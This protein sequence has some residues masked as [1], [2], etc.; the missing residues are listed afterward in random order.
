MYSAGRTWNFVPYHKR[1]YSSSR[2]GRAFDNTR[3]SLIL[4]RWITSRTW[5]LERVLKLSQVPIA[6]EYTC[7]RI[8]DITCNSITTD[9]SPIPHAPSVRLVLTRRI[10]RA[11]WMR[12]GSQAWLLFQDLVPFN[13]RWSSDIFVPSKEVV[14]RSL[15]HIM[16]VSKLRKHGW[17]RVRLLQTALFIVKGY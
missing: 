12:N 10:V 15:L 2:N 16:H 13:H 7:V 5:F 17:L 11:S 9:L 8:A 4:Q 1:H 14:L 6:K 3:T